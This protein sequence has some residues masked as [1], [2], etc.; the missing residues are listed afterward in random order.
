MTMTAFNPGRR[1]IHWSLTICAA[2]LLSCSDAT[3]PPEP[4]S[5]DIELSIATGP[6]PRISWTPACGVSQVALTSVPDA[7]GDPARTIW[8]FTVP[9]RS[10]IG[11]AV[12]Y[13]ESPRSAS[14]W[15]DPESLEIGVPY[16]VRVAYTVG[17]D[18]LVASGEATFTWFPPD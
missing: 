12:T 13:G 7:P 16:R 11:P 14:V 6:A 15:A 1:P 18:V 3:S 9:E 4:C 8:G 2:A 10:P 5:G 17:G